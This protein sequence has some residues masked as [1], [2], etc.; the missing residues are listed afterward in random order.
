MKKCSLVVPLETTTPEGYRVTYSRL[1][2]R[3]PEKFIY[4]DG[5]RYW[6]MLTDLWL[7]LHG[8]EPGHVLVADITGVQ[9]THALKISPVGVKKYLYY[10]QEA[11]PIK[12]KGLHFLHTSPVMDFI[13]GLMKPFM[14]KELMDVVRIIHCFCI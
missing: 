12:I 1:I 14:K 3:D 2:D 10:L 11:L 13:L 8:T 9:M 4:N 7:H 5:M 6:N